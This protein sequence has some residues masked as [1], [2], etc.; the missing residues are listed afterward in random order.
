MKLV[1]PEIA[2]HNRDP[3]YACDL[4]PP[5]EG[6]ELQR[7]ATCGPDRVIRI[8]NISFHDDYK[9]KVEFLSSLLRHSK[10]VNVVRFSPNGHYLASGGDDNA[11]IIWKLSSTSATSNN[12]LQEDDGEITEVWVSGK[13]L[14]GHLGDIY[15][16]SWSSDGKQLI[17]GSID[18]SAILWDVKKA[19]RLAIFP[20]HKSF[21]QGVS[22]D[23]KGV[24][25]AT[26][27]ADRV[28]RIYNVQSKSCQYRI[29]KWTYKEKLRKMF[30]DDTM[31]SFFR[32]L[33]FSPD[34]NLLVVPSG[35]VECDENDNV[36]TTFVLGRHSWTK[37]I[38]HLPVIGKTTLAV[39]FC[40]KLFKLR[41]PEAGN[42]IFDLPY[43]MI[44]AVASE[45]S[46]VLYDTQQTHPF[47]LISN[48]HYQ[49]LT[50]LTWSADATLLIIASSDGYV[51]IVTFE[52][53]ELGEFYEKPPILSYGRQDSNLS[54]NISESEK[55]ADGED[56][57]QSINLSRTESSEDNLKTPQTIKD[58]E[59]GGS[60]NTLELKQTPS[61]TKP[62]QNLND[63]PKTAKSNEVT[64]SPATSEK[65]GNLKPRR[66]QLTTLSSVTQ[67]KSQAAPRR[68][69]VTTL[70]TLWGSQ[71]K[72]EKKDE[73]K[74]VDEGKPSSQPVDSD[75]DLQLENT[76]DGFVDK[77][78]DID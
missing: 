33:S 25:I 40:P 42:K 28:C 34:G 47:S 41:E 74:E 37:P 16:I 56:A 35:Y 9:V 7:L 65:A 71:K 10:A 30:Y 23:P 11:I 29:V 57:D 78:M 2:W 64:I 75:C 1:T 48:I 31:K 61:K 4:Q 6:S 8:W 52:K 60:S 27:C 20:E 19:C 14:R 39:R 22:F 66:V 76:N 73:P 38:M 3:I 21:V 69:Q 67:P 44:F 26:H 32:R 46:V 45:E 59:E 77:Q 63:T 54:N 58:D 18:N 70:S 36:N 55:N 72:V 24:Y 12:T 51:S 50:D 53:G 43:R 5:Q 15:D 68:V 17:S 62:T 13:V 49:Q